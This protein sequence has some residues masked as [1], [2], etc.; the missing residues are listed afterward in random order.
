M[1]KLN[2]KYY[3]IEELGIWPIY[4]TD[5]EAVSEGQQ[6]LSL[7]LKRERNSQIV[8]QAKEYFKARNNG[9]LF[10]EVCKFD[11]S[12]KYGLIGEGFIEAHHT[13]PVSKMQPGD[14]TRIEDFI[15]VCSN[16]HSML[17]VGGNYLSYEDLKS[18]IKVQEKSENQYI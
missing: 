15:M 9:K 17:H 6:K 11:F 4:S 18:R 10:C 13:K 14:T 5:M 8:K 1:E 12:K 3:D 16:C 7:H 2:I